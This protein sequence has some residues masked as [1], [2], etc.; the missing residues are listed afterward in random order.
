MHPVS[1]EFAVL[2]AVCRV[3]TF[4]FSL[5]TVSKIA[6]VCCVR[7]PKLRQFYEL[8]EARYHNCPIPSV[9][10]RAPSRKSGGEALY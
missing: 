3:T 5:V 10:I 2:S 1:W 9:A 4:M 8:D 7:T 6:A